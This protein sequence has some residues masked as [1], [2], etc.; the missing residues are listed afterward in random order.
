[1]PNEVQVQSDIGA[2]SIHGLG[3]FSMV[4]ATLS[5]DN[6]APMALVQ[7]EKLGNSFLISGRFAA[8]V[9]DLLR[10]F[11]AQPLG[12]LAAAIGWRKGDSASL[13]AETAG[14]QAAALLS[15]L[16]ANLFQFDQRGEI[17]SQLCSRLL[18]TEFSVASVLQLAEITDFLA[19]KLFPLGF[20]NF[21]PDQV[22][23]IHQAYSSLGIE[24]PTD[25]LDSLTV[26]AAVDLLY[27][28]CQ[29]L[30]D[31]AKIVRI[32][33]S[34]TMGHILGLVLF[35]F[36]HDT[37]ITVE[38]IV[39][40]EGE[41]HSL[42][43]ELRKDPPGPVTITVENTIDPS[44]PFHSSI[45]I[46]SQR[47][48][49]LQ[50]R[51]QF[52]WQGWIAKGMELV[53]LEVGSVCT[54]EVLVAFVNLLVAILRQKIP[55]NLSPKE[56]GIAHHR[57]ATLLGPIP[58]L[59]IERFCQT[60]LLSSFI[61]SHLDLRT[62]FSAFAQIVEC[63]I[64]LLK[65]CSCTKTKCALAKGWSEAREK[66][67]KECH[68]YRMWSKVGAFLDAGVLCFFINGGANAT[69]SDGR[70]LSFHGTGRRLIKKI[71]FEEEFC[72]ISAQSVF[73]EIM[74]L[75]S[76]LFR[77]TAL[78]SSCGSTIYPTVLKTLQI[79]SNSVASFELL[80]GKLIFEERYYTDLSSAST[81]LRPKAKRSVTRKRDEI[82]PS[83]IG[84]HESLLMTVQE[85]TSGLKVRTTARY[86]GTNIHLGLSEIIQASLSLERT[87]ACL[88]PSTNALRDSSHEVVLTGIS[89]PRS[90][91]R[92]SI[93]VAMTQS[94]P[95]AQLLCCEPGA[96]MILMQD[97]C[98]K[99]A[100]EEAAS[101]SFD[102]I[103]V[104]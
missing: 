99:C 53:F 19:Q 28:I 26:D 11:T 80:D 50:T 29:A 48:V 12:R 72:F 31:E 100:L 1:M 40:H 66:S 84:E 39:I 41:R 73:Q 76:S 81:T 17:L 104:S 79:P 46:E 52:T 16:L 21:L 47:S 14:G 5:T 82:N 85:T 25:L 68:V 32:S 86:A 95:T 33:G 15:T 92:N 54:Q 94:N 71:I 93:A 77:E 91:K 30:R 101:G 67:K 27:S 98:L 74:G 38:D 96:N 37:V 57:L 2:L 22:V 24:P 87:S 4:V 65:K 56:N 36:P 58:H 88:H 34:F 78:A 8:R 6:I 35:M 42:Y 70:S 20:G 3:A 60:L 13:L 43:V 83:N 97:C 55:Y 9:P 44:G 7:M 10:R 45:K 61:P 89:A 62:A 69:I 49:D 103:I 59:R 102:V 23:K 51:Y 63:T 18:P 90:S 75:V 64:N